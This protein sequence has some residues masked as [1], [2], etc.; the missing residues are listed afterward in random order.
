M[1]RPGTQGN[2]EELI[3]ELAP[4]STRERASHAYGAENPAEFSDD[5]DLRDPVKVMRAIRESEVWPILEQG[6]TDPVEYERRQSG[7]KHVV[8]RNRMDGDPVLAACG[9]MFSRRPEIES[10]RASNLSNDNFWEAAGY[11]RPPGKGTWY[12][13]VVELE[14]MVEGIERA[15][16][17]CWQVAQRHDSR[18][19]RHYHVDGTAYESHSRW[20]HECPDPTLCRALR[21][22]QQVPEY[23]ERAGAKE[24]EADR[25]ERHE[26]PLDAPDLGLP[27]GPLVAPA[28]ADDLE[29]Q[30][31]EANERLDEQGHPKYRKR[32][33]EREPRQER[34][35]WRDGHRYVCRD[36]ESGY[37]RIGGP[38]TRRRKAK[39]WNG[40]IGLQPTEDVLG[41][42]PCTLHIPADVNEHLAIE[43]LLCKQM[44]ITRSVPEAYVGDRGASVRPVKERFNELGIGLVS[45]YRAQNGNGVGRERLRTDDHD[46]Y[47]FRTCDHCGGPCKRTGTE[48]RGAHLVAT[49]RCVDPLTPQCNQE[50]SVPCD[51]EPLLFG[52]VS[53]DEDLYFELR[54]GANR[55]KE[56]AHALARA[57]HA[58]LGDSLPIRPKRIGIEHMDLRAA[59]ACFLDIFRVC[60]RFGWIGNWP[61]RHA[62]VVR[63]RS[64]L[65]GVKGLR[66]RRA[67]K[68]LLL[69]RG[70]KA[71]ELGLTFTGELPPGWEPISER[72]KEE[73]DARRKARLANARRIVREATATRGSPAQTRAG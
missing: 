72:H 7:E 43:D 20:H 53:R 39:V 17:Y 47:G 30:A 16:A 44:R 65:Q 40:G 62:Y 70:P 9:W 5:P 52:V 69:P 15:T 60:L 71:D 4:N 28:E 11:T 33:A 27:E 54:S 31:V 68:G 6:C 55:N 8:G 32:L 37:R 49:F 67:S 21:Q 14:S 25:K 61:K 35:V 1:Y 58:T 19:G 23:L 64:G 29:E 51:V 50:Q 26:Q 18:I 22:L 12:D 42:T 63:R 36:G 38:G 56:N 57:R 59:L 3:A 34:E 45:P 10:F 41:I 46:E 48:R 13:R 66:T 2:V 24:I 73:R